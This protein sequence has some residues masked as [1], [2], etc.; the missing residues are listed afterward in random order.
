MSDQQLIGMRRAA[1]RIAARACQLLGDKTEK[2]DVIQAVSSALE[3]IA[4]E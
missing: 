3:E 4:K 1:Q 2:E